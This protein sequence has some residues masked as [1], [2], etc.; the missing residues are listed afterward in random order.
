MV[1]VATV[2]PVLEIWKGNGE[3]RNRNRNTEDNEEVGG[4]YRERGEGERRVM[5]E[6]MKKKHTGR[7]KCYQKRRDGLIKKMGVKA[8]MHGVRRGWITERKKQRRG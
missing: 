5:K 8:N 1:L 3:Q 6:K 7:K 2:F 4:K